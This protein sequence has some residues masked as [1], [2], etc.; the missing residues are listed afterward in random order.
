MTDKHSSTT[1]HTMRL[2]RR[3][4]LYGLSV[5]TPEGWLV[6]DTP[7]KGFGKMTPEQWAL[8]RLRAMK[9]RGRTSNK[10]KPH[11]TEPAMRRKTTRTRKCGTTRQPSSLPSGGPLHLQE[12]LDF[13]E[14]CFWE[15]GGAAKR[16]GTADHLNDVQGAA[17]LGSRTRVSSS[18]HRRL[19]RNATDDEF[20]HL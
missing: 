16:D 18:R 14:A 1:P 15:K 8:A 19:M 2:E 17:D 7:I 9:A 4:I 12:I 5:L 6:F 10:P 3:G 11:Q 13:R 20:E